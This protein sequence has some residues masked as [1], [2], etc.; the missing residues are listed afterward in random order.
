[1]KESSPNPSMA[2]DESPAGEADVPDQRR[3]EAVDLFA[4]DG[5]AWM[6]FGG[7]EF[8]ASVAGLKTD[9]DG[10]PA[11]GPDENAPISAPTSPNRLLDPS[12]D[13]KIHM[14]MPSSPASVVDFRS[15][16]KKDPPAMRQYA[17]WQNAS[18]DS[19]HTMRV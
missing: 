9:K 4:V 12:S 18:P 15:K 3:E 17:P 1:M 7:S 6:A 11:T 10:F 8:F 16:S 2:E 19:M 13:K 14:K 5:D